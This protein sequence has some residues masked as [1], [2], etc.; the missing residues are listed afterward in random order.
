MLSIGAKAPDFNLESTKGPVALSKIE[1][2][3]LIV[4][5]PR[6]NTPGCT[7]QLCAAQ[8]NLTG[9]KSLNV[10]VIA[11]NYGSLASHQKYAAKYTLDFPLCVDTNKEVAKL[12]KAATEEGKIIRTVYILDE[13]KNIQ[14]AKQGSPTTAELMDALE[15]IN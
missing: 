12:Y 7:K 10:N 3:V 1:G 4:F 15:T 11:I 2:K 6:D 8:D 5:Y 13:N 14:Y 9:Y